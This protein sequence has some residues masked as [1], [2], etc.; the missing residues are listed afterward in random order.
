MGKDLKGKELGKGIGQQKNGLYT[1]RFVDKTG[2]RRSK[3]SKS[4]QVVRRWL[5]E[6]SNADRNSSTYMTVNAWFA[7]WIKIKEQTVRPN[8][9]RNYRERYQ[10]NIRQLIMGHSSIGI[11]MNL[12]V[13][14]T[15]EEKY[16]E[17]ERAADALKVI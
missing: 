6:A 16:K 11:T 17:I 12:Y 2:T 10:H 4:L 1:G 5:L 8:T 15:D 14:I 9:V 3:R 7:Y 13:H